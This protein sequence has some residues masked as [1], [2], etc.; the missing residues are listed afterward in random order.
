MEEKA[1]EMTE[2]PDVNDDLSINGRC[3]SKFHSMDDKT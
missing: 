1:T 2:D 3:K